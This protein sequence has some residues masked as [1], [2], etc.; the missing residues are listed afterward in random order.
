MFG[1]DGWGSRA[2]RNAAMGAMVL[3]DTQVAP[4]GGV[5]APASLAVMRCCIKH[6]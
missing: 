1:R 2:I 5:K 3:G 6:V 4:F